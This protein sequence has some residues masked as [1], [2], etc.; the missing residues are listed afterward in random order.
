V[1]PISYSRL[2]LSGRPRWKAGSCGW[3]KSIVLRGWVRVRA[4]RA[5]GLQHRRDAFV[6]EMIGVEDQIHTTAGG[7]EG[8]LA[9]AGMGDRLFAETVGLAHHDLGLVLGEGG[10]ELAI[11]AAAGCRRVRS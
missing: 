11:L 4:D 7:V 5:A 10:D 3:V 2:V 1:Q 8:G 6:V 9:A